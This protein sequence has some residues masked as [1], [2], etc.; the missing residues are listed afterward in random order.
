MPWVS[1]RC[2]IAR[3]P[4]GSYQQGVSHVWDVLRS[5]FAEL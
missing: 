1:H 3:L 5:A 4:K 2:E